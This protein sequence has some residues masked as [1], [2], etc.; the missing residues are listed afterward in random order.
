MTDIAKHFIDAIEFLDAG[1]STFE[2]DGTRTLVFCA[3]GVNQSVILVIAYLMKANQWTLEKSF[4]LIKEKRPCVNPAA[5]FIGQ[6]SVFEQKLFDG[7]TVFTL[8]TM[9]RKSF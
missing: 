9:K 5:S 3:A 7:K 4:E 1:K 6:L 8:K 2:K